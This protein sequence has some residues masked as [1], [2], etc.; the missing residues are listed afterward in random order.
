M[1]ETRTVLVIIVRPDRSF[2][3]FGCKREGA[4][5]TFAGQDIKWGRSVKS[6]IGRGICTESRK[7]GLRL[8]GIVF[9]SLVAIVIGFQSPPLILT[10]TD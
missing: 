4:V 1:H 10:Q 7:L 2:F 5:H 3:L 9:A 8:I 6:G